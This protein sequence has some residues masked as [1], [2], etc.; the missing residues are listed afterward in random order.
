MT[1]KLTKRD[2]IL[3]YFLAIFLIITGFTAL[4]IIPSWN[5]ADELSANLEEAQSTRDRMD[6]SIAMIPQYTTELEEKQNQRDQLIADIYPVMENQAVDKMITNLILDYGLDA[7]D[8]IISVDPQMRQI[9]PY[10]LSSMGL[11]AMTTAQGQAEEI[12]SQGTSSSAES[13]LDGTASGD[14]ASADGTVSDGS[15]A[16][17]NTGTVMEIYT[18]DVSVKAVGSRE[19]LQSLLDYIVNEEPSIRITGYN[20]ASEA[21]AFETAENA[22]MSTLTITM[23]LYMC[24]K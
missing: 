14:G 13:E 20:F 15:S 12:I 22:G 8:F 21:G 7:K 19:R 5:R 2:K 9:A 24:Y 16:S 18:S 23:E 17:S 6:T 10:S 1:T 11:K 4:L 3:L